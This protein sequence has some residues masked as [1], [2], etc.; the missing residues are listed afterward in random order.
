MWA[1]QKDV[2]YAFKIVIVGAGGVGK[3]C[4]F[5]RYCFNSF[6]MNTEMTIGIN[7]HSTYLRI[8]KAGSH[9]TDQEKY[10]ANS[11]FDMSG[12]EK[13]KPLIKKFID[14]ASGALLV[15][16]SVSFLSFQQ[17]DYW[18][19]QVMQNS[20]DPNIPII[21]VG[22]KSDLLTKTPEWEQ[23]S[24]EVIQEYIK[25]RNIADFSRTSALENYNVLEVFKKLTNLM[26]KAFKFPA[27]VV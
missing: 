14:G 6:N 9:N 7:F 25:E 8:Q 24:E 4:L 22:S 16:D 21:L 11:I 20:V 5:N 18:Y 10:V 17:L 26:L 27:H 23:V 1:A 19:E 13:F 3:T 12:Q 15:F 2:E